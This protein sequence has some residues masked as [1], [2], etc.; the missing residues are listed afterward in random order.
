MPRKKDERRLR[1]TVCLPADVAEALRA[2]QEQ[3]ERVLRDVMKDPL[4]LSRVSLNATIIVALRDFYN[5]PTG[6]V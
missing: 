2:H 6:E 4:G 1:F 3:L 5:L